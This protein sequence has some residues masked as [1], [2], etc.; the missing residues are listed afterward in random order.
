M[1]NFHLMAPFEDSIRIPQNW[2]FSGYV[3][4]KHYLNRKLYLEAGKINIHIANGAKN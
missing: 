3:G 2:N 1:E 4:P